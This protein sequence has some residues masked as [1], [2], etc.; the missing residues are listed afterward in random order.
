MKAREDGIVVFELPNQ[1]REMVNRWIDDLTLLGNAWI[2]EELV[3][4]LI[5]MRGNETITP[6]NSDSLKKV[7]RATAKTDR[8]RTAF[9]FDPHTTIV[10]LADRFLGSLGPL[11]G[12]KRVFVDED[13]AIAWLHKALE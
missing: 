11:L 2:E 5:D 12:D 9:L 3:L 7:S 4:L 10:A 8:I 6:Y 1:S 13:E